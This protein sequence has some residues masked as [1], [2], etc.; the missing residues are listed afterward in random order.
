MNKLKIAIQ[1]DGRLSDS[2]KKLLVECGL[3]FS[4]GTGMLKSVVTNFPAEILYLR[5]DDI[6]QYVEQGVADAGIIGEN[7]VAEKSK[8][9]RIVERLGFARCRLSLAIPREEEYTGPEFFNGK[10]IA[11]SYPNILSDYLRKN[12]IKA[13]IEEIS[14]SVEIAP[15]IG[16][17]DAVCDIVSSGST[18]MTNGLKEV[19]TIL[20]SQAVLVVN[21]KLSGKKSEILDKLLFRIRAVKNAGENKYILLN[22]PESAVARIAEILPGMK[23]PTILPLV[24]KGWVSLHSVVREDDFWESINMLKEAGAEGILVIP[25]EKMI[26]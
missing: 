3:K 11:T 26:K 16:L 20:T 8:D 5:D 15:G 7:M 25:I 24:E 19:V 12:N 17:A 9:I 4:N 6:P 21:K 2:S 10:K 1:K 23:S 13:A 18:L 14:G 22:A